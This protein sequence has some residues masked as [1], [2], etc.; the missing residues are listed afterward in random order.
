MTALIAWNNLVKS[1]TL[2]ASSED[3]PIG[4]I[5]TDSGSAADAWQ[6]ENGDVTLATGALFTVTPAPASTWRVFGVFR[7]NLT[8]DAVVHFGLWNDGSPP[9]L[10]TDVT[11]SPVNGYG[12]AVAVLPANTTADFLQ[13]YIEDSGNPD[14]HIN[15]PQVFAGTAWFPARSIG[16]SSTVGRDVSRSDVT[17]RAGQV[18]PTLN[19]RRRRWNIQLESLLTAEVWGQVDD[20]LMLAD[21]GTNLL[22]VPDIASSYL[23]REAVFGQ[24]GALAD[25]SFPYQSADRRRWSAQIVERL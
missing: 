23:Q 5:A 11:A 9:T 24:L 10:V 18:Y 1:A 21:T 16:F 19:F 25:V 14:N 3:L 20:L 7:T 12:Q 13:V 17:T 22:F 4:N 2:A 15:I 6:T 8:S